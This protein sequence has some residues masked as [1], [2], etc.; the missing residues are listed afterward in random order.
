VTLSV[1]FQLTRLK[2]VLLVSLI[3]VML[4]VECRLS[5]FTDSFVFYWV[6]SLYIV[7]IDVLIS[8]AAQLQECL[9]NL[10]A[11]LLKPDTIGYALSVTFSF[12]CRQTWTCYDLNR[13]VYFLQFSPVGTPGSQQIP[14]S[15]YTPLLS[16][17]K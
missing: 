2:Q 3:T 6:L 15:H 9:I 14:P 13:N 7:L 12:Y 4:H 17:V 5:Y 16:V 1:L 10:L 8:S 11:Y